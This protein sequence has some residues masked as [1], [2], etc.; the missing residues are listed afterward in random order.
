[1]RGHC[2]QCVQCVLRRIGSASDILGILSCRPSTPCVLCALYCECQALQ[3]IL[4]PTELIATSQRHPTLRCPHA[5]PHC[6]IR[7]PSHIVTFGDSNDNRFG[8][9]VGTP[10]QTSDWARCLIMKSSRQIILFLCSVYYT[11]IFTAVRSD[12]VSTSPSHQ[13]PA[14]VTEICGILLLPYWGDLA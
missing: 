5:I 1:M 8:Y 3:C 6:D 2:V 10:F 4:S 7:T 12:P 13:C 9:D 11:L 14:A